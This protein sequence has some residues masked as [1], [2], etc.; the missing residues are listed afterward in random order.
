MAQAQAAA[1]TAAP[2]GQKR[3]RWAD[4]TPDERRDARADRQRTKEENA[5]R[6]D[7]TLVNT[8]TLD[9]LYFTQFVNKLDHTMERLRKVMGTR[10]SKV[11]VEDVMQTTKD[12]D[13]ITGLINIICADISRMANVPYRAPRGHLDLRKGNVSPKVVAE[14]ESTIK[15]LTKKKEAIEAKL[16]E[17]AEQ[18]AK[19]AEAANAKKE[20]TTEK[21]EAPAAKKVSAKAKAD[22]GVAAAAA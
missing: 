7:T 12:L 20:A 18:Q 2:A 14:L 13:A 11:E 16:A 17:R 8:K 15:L 5:K 21:K 6:P 19:Q 4:M 22:T 1:P 3:K 10:G 9:A